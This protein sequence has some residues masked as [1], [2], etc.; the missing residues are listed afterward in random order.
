MGSNQEL[1]EQFFGSNEKDGE[2]LLNS[3]ERSL[4]QL[5]YTVAS[6]GIH[7][8]QE[9]SNGEPDDDPDDEPGDDDYDYDEDSAL[10]FHEQI[11][12]AMDNFNHVVE[13]FKLSSY[14]KNAFLE[15]FDHWSSIR[16]NNVKR[17]KEIADEMQT[18][19]FNSDIAKVVGGVVGVVGGNLFIIFSVGKYGT[20]F[21]PLVAL[22]DIL[23][24]AF[25]QTQN[26]PEVVFLKHRYYRSQVDNIGFLELS[27]ETIDSIHFLK[28]VDSF[29]PDNTI[30][31]RIFSR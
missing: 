1:F 31:R 25:L 15:N 3:T 22:R 11:E 24:F 6:R 21:N 29:L 27:T 2:V 17:L 10:N 20:D 9:D 16:K 23:N 18:D 30:D 19:K 7:E 14:A 28:T 8:G 13:L 5:I 26:K 12:A 4:A